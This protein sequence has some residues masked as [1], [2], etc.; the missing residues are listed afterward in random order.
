MLVDAVRRT[1]LLAEPPYVLTIHLKRF[2]ISKAGYFVKITGHVPFPEVLDVAPFMATKALLPVPLASA[3]GGGGGDDDS[4]VA[5]AASAL[6]SASPSSSSSSQPCLYR[7]SGV[8]VHSGGLSGGHYI[9]HVRYGEPKPFHYD[10]VRLA[11][12]AGACW[13]GVS[14]GSVTPSTLAS[15]L[16]AEAYILFYERVTTAV[17]AAPA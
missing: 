16:A 11:P 10:G 17:A 8:V 13:A 9:A 7:L 15:A 4:A 5:A 1:L 12:D 3:G 14:D 2:A 6:A